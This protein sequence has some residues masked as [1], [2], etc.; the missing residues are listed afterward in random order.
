MLVFLDQGVE[1]IGEA[2]PNRHLNLNHVAF[3]PSL[4]FPLRSA[5]PHK[6]LHRFS[7]SEHR[8][9]IGDGVK[10][11]CGSLAGKSSEAPSISKL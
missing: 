3:P 2:Q 4:K 7:P 11:P 5:K 1:N 9:A 8:S 10:S 6:A